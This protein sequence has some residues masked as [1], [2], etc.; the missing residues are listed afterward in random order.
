MR[1]HINVVCFQIAEA[2]SDP[3]ESFFGIH[4]QMATVQSKNASFH[5]TGTLA[6][7]THNKTSEWLNTLSSSQRD[8]LLRSAVRQGRLLKRQTDKD[9]SEAATEK[10][11][12]LE[13]RS[14]AMKLAEK[15]LIHDLL[16]LRDKELFKTTTRYEL[17]AD[18]VKDNFSKHLCE[19]KQQIRLLRKVH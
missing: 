15:K 7:W 4:D 2:T 8:L 3:I 6:T 19:L 10:L 14:K 18:T 13:K 16:N 1:I 11:K 12:R 5:V 17:F 9:I